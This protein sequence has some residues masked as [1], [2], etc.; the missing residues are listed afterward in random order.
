MDEA[1]AFPTNVPGNF[2]TGVVARTFGNIG[3]KMFF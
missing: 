1:W 2:D 3:L